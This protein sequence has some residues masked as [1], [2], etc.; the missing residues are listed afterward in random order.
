[1]I[2]AST[3]KLESTFPLVVPEDALRSLERSFTRCTNGHSMVIRQG[4]DGGFFW[5]CSLFPSCRKTKRLTPDQSFRIQ[6]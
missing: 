1:M 2:N 4:P 5:G 3:D 6:S